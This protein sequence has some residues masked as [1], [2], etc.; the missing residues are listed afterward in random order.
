MIASGPLLSTVGPA[1]VR[2]SSPD[3]YAGLQGKDYLAARGLSTRVAFK[4][5]SIQSE[6]CGC[7]PCV[8][9]RLLPAVLS[10]CAA[11]N[12]RQARDIPQTNWNVDSDAALQALIDH[13]EPES[14]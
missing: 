8:R 7:T 14:V 1:R 13:A 11:Q 2:I 3:P 12:R 10:M 6:E 9:A 4:G 5:R